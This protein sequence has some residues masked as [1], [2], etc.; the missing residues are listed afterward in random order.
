MQKF[1]AIIFDMDGVII[2]SEALHHESMR[3]MAAGQGVQLTDTLLDEFI[4]IPDLQL[5]EHINR[6]YLGGRQSVSALL[7]AKQQAF[8]QLADRIRE[9]PGAVDFIQRSRPQFAAFGLA[10]S[11]LRANQ[12][13]AFDRF[14]L[15]RYFD[16]V[17]TAEDVSR[18]KPDPE[19]Y[20]RAAEQLGVSAQR[21]V[22]IEDSRNGVRSAKA[23]GC[24]VIGLTTTYPADALLAAGA[25]VVWSSYD[26]IAAYL[27]ERRL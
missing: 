25:D 5:V 1:Q 23:A 6:H 26:E 3:A 24:H 12:Q 27:P 20:L 22:A 13:L 8:L 21:S 15:H 7:Q 14:G 16:A 11:A 10:T 4:G 2:D 17:V 19:P 18:T 9:I